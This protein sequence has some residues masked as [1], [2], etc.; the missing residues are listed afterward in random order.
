LK[1]LKGGRTVREGAMMSGTMAAAD[2]LRIG[3]HRRWWRDYDIILP[4]MNFYRRRRVGWSRA[5]VF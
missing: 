4:Y 3:K 1:S 2:E 5:D